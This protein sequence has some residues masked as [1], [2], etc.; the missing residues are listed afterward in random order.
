M[1]GIILHPGAAYALFGREKKQIDEATARTKEVESYATALE[2]RVKEVQ[3]QYLQL[4]E[5]HKQLTVDRDNLLAQLKSHQSQTGD[6]EQVRAERDLLQ[7]LLKKSS[8]EERR[9]REQLAETDARRHEVQQALEQLAQ[10]RAAL[11]RQL[12]GAKRRSKETQ[13]TS[14]VNAQRQENAELNRV[15]RAAQRELAESQK[16]EVSLHQQLKK[17]QGDYTASVADNS[18]LRN[19]I[20][21]IPKDVDRIARE[22][23][24]L[25]KENADMH[26][27]LGVLFSQRK[28][29]PRALS[30]F[31]KVVELRPDDGD[32]Y[33]NLGII[34]AEHLPDREKAMAHFKR[35]L[36]LNP[37]AKDSGWVKQYIA[38]WRAWEVEERLE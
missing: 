19:Q 33:Y 5:A 12:D 23:Q 3:Q 27:N 20:R 2:Q 25:L 31:R 17:L 38:S 16:R 28:D 14:E 1:G 37:H 6:Y 24:R 10:E 32:A 22:H 30:E 4:D 7:Q 8:E 21:T 9:L 36:T 34:Y 15:L 35:Y 29:Y 13:L 11:A 18:T 26:Y